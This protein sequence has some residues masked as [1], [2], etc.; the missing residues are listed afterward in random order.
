MTPF[1]SKL[2]QNNRNASV[3]LRSLK[4]VVIKI[5][6]YCTKSNLDLLHIQK[7]I[8]FFHQKSSQLTYKNFLKYFFISFTK[9]TMKNHLN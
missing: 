5:Y 2:T 8:F 9:K 4:I 6:I 3:D 1:K 7:H